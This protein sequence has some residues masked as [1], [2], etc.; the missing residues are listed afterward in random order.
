MARL[1]TF[2]FLVLL[3]SVG[4]CVN[5]E[6]PTIASKNEETERAE[7]QGEP[8]KQEE[9]AVNIVDLGQV[10]GYRTSSASGREILAFRGVP[11]AEPPVGDL[12]FQVRLNI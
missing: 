7:Y 2:T 12:R 3:I 4:R 8:S 6:T 5:S 9:P 11:Y 1:G 10:R